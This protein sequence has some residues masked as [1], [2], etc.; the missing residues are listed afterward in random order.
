MG[1]AGRCQDLNVQ[2]SRTSSFTSNTENFFTDNTSY[3]PQ[4]KL[5]DYLNGG[6]MYWR[7]AAK[8]ADNNTGAWTTFQPITLPT[9]FAVTVSPGI[10]IH[11]KTTTVTVTVKS[12]DDHAVA[13]ARVAISGAGLKATAKTHRHARQGDVQAAPA[14][15]G[16]DH[17]LGHEDRTTRR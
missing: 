6:T 12:F 10:L 7:V 13:G 8:D 15:E 5:T 4:L 3:A 2:I 16:H 9:K 11:G 14:E 1:H 17:L